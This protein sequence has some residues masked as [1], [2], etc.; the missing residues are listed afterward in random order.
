M[1]NTEKG[2]DAGIRGA[3]VPNFTD[4]GHNKGTTRTRKHREFIKLGD[5]E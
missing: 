2:T 1:V 4:R 3:N 5:C